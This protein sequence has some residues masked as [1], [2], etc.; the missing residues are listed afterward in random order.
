MAFPREA[1]HVSQ[2]EMGCYHSHT[3]EY[4]VGFLHSRLNFTRAGADDARD[5]TL[6]YAPRS[7]DTRDVNAENRA[8]VYS[9]NHCLPRYPDKPLSKN[10]SWECLKMGEF[11]AYHNYPHYSGFNPLSSIT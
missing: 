8:R 5:Q 4:V 2:L 10:R 11:L 9:Q 3:E 7:S 6:A 1:R